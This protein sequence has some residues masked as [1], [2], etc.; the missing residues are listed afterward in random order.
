MRPDLDKCTTECYRRG[1]GSLEHTYKIKFGGT[2]KIDSDP[3]AE[4]EN[5]RGGFHSSA[6]HRHKECKD[7]GD[8]LGALRGNIH[9]NVGRP[10]NDV[11]SEF[12]KNLDRRSVSGHHIWTHLKYEVELN[13]IFLSGKVY[14]STKKWGYRGGPVTGYYVH[15]IT[16]ILEYRRSISWRTRYRN[17]PTPIDKLQIPVPGEDGWHYCLLEGLWFR[18]KLTMVDGWSKIEKKSA[19]RKEIAWIKAQIG[20]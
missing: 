1:A 13:T 6:R 11:F 19:N 20:V 8:K 2:V 14:T 12:C 3:D 18:Q 10:W 16:G 7:F 5:E 17:K 9:K 4:Y 15:P